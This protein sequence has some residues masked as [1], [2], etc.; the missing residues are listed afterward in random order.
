MLPY[1][2]QASDLVEFLDSLATSLQA[3][4]VDHPVTIL[5][6]LCAYCAAFLPALVDRG[7]L[8]PDQIR[9]DQYGHLYQIIPINRSINIIIRPELIPEYWRHTLR[10]SADGYVIGGCEPLTHGQ[11][12]VNPL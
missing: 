1:Q 9:Q 3:L 2:L 4:E 12:T 8:L 7:W 6:E 5:V 11:V 10:I